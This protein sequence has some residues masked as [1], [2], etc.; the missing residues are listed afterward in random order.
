MWEGELENTGIVLVDAPDLFIYNT[1]NSWSSKNLY[2]IS[3]NSKIKRK[4]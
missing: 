4:G 3:H 2:F 1:T